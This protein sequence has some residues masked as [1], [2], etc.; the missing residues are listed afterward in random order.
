MTDTRRRAFVAATPKEGDRVDLDPDESHHVA[1]VLRLKPGDALSVFDG[2]DAEWEATIDA[3]TRERVSVVV[4]RPLPGVVEPAL[5]VVLY[6]ALVRPEK[7]EWVLQK[8][9]EVGVTAFRLVASDRVEAPP[10]SPGRLARYARIV[11]EACKQSGRRFLPALSSGALEAPPAGVVAIVLG[12]AQGVDTIGAV[13][14]GPRAEDVWLAVGPEGGFSEGELEVL[15]R[16]GWQRAS[17]GPRVLRTE[18]AGAVA[19]AIVLHT[20][21]DLGPKAARP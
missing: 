14:A 12:H 19:A 10:P 7:L 18:T 8:G 6:Q 13:L 21:G 17:L 4:G 5:R 11:M 2:K 9:T 15:I 20:W 1:R 16:A 3:A